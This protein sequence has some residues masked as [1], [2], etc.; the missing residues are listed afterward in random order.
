MRFVVIEDLEEVV[1][2]ES[3]AR[4]PSVVGPQEGIVFR[5]GGMVGLLAVLAKTSCYLPYLVS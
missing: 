4:R 5:P 2:R 1:V 3:Q